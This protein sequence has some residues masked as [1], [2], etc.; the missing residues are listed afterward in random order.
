MYW[1]HP[2]T[3]LKLWIIDDRS[4][5]QKAN[6]VQGLKA[7]LSFADP[8]SHFSLLLFFRAVCTRMRGSP[9]QSGVGQ[10]AARVAPETSPQL[11]RR[12]PLL[13]KEHMHLCMQICAR[14]PALASNTAHRNTRERKL[15]SAKV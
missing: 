15:C 2:P 10:G 4:E 13:W 7:A 5:D 8:V 6:V 9:G 1:R 11:L 14:G 12:G 3:S